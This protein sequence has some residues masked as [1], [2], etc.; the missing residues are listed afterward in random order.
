MGE[1][2]HNG[3]KGMGFAYGT[4]D[5][6]LADK[7]LPFD[8]VDVYQLAILA[9]DM[10]RFPREDNRNHRWRMGPRMAELR[11]SMPRCA[12]ARGSPREAALT[13]RHRRVH[14]FVRAAGHTSRK[15]RMSVWVRAQC[16]SR[17]LPP[18]H[19]AWTRRAGLRARAGRA[20]LGRA[21]QRRAAGGQAAGD[22]REPRHRAR[23]AHGV[24]QPGAVPAG[25]VRLRLHPGRGR[26][27]RDGRGVA[28]LRHRAGTQELGGPAWMPCASL[29]GRSLSRS[30]SA[31]LH[32]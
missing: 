24:Q 14:A 5:E 10:A 22:G 30:I 8:K 27:H 9:T 18:S 1:A 21:V 13:A 15:Y 4:P 2:R 11:E 25:L 28:Q 26:A 6:N 32:F 23:G 31:P 7:T 17:P 29:A 19:P 12:L 20:A 3:A 16:V